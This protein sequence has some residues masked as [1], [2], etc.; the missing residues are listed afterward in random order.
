M[1]SLIVT[2]AAT[3]ALFAG[4]VLV[5]YDTPA[6]QSPPL[7]YVVKIDPP[8]FSATAGAPR[9]DRA[10]AAPEFA[11]ADQPPFRPMMGAEA[12][13]DARDADRAGDDR[14][15]L[16]AAPTPSDLAAAPPPAP[17]EAPFS[18]PRSPVARVEPPASP[19]DQRFP[20]PR[21]RSPFDTVFAAT[22]D[23]VVDTSAIAASADN[24]PAQPD[25]TSG[26]GADASPSPRPPSN[27]W[28]ATTATTPTPGSD[29]APSAFAATEPAPQPA[30]APRNSG[31]SAA[32]IPTPPLPRKRAQS[33]PPIPRDATSSIAPAAP[34]VATAGSEVRNAAETSVLFAAN[35]V[36]P[37]AAL[38]REG[39]CKVGL[40]VRDL[41][42]DERETYSAINSLKPAVS[43]AFTPHGR[44]VKGWAMRALQTGH[45]VF[46]GVPMEPS[47]PSAEPAPPNML[48]A[49]LSTDENM[50]RLDAVLSLVD[51][52]S[53]VINIMGGKLAQT[54]EAVKPFMLALKRR[55][56]AYV[57]DGAAAHPYAIL[58][59]AQLDVRY[60]IADAKIGA[61][62]SPAAIQRE[63]A[64]VEE[65]ACK[66]GD[67]LA[68]ANADAETLR[69]IVIWS[70]GLEARNV[71][72]V[73]ASQ[74]V[75]AVVLP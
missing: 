35:A 38:R 36:A 63:L 9:D 21:A 55:G 28:A 10:A 46:L 56:L 64:A 32:T 37:A 53:G 43:L 6:P 44:D 7:R 41:G 16:D 29:P 11:R 65:M 25:A 66:K 45:E 75:T 72:L 2:A 23:G 24:E 42:E 60:R 8:E 52:H 62:P 31:S 58:L 26:D 12:P 54:P 13:P 20:A 5:V 18:G 68:I 19:F 27:D 69:Q 1:K 34:V 47:A 74:I 71:S 49:S 33:Q 4:G 17:D 15:P 50:K 73:P 3:I 40:I 59:A 70:A 61:M 48:L 67:A 51:G 39:A 57:D 30:A 14:S 22:P